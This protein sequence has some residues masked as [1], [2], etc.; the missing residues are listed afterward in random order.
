MASAEA[1]AATSVATSAPASDCRE[2]EFV[3]GHKII[4]ATSEEEVCELDNRPEFFLFLI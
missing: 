4:K 1:A 2:I 3:Q